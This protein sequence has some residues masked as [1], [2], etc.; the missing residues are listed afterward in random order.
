MSSSANK[1]LV[2]A[3]HDNQI[4]NDATLS[5]ISAA[6]AISAAVEV[7]VIGCNCLEVANQLSG[8][9]GVTKVILVEHS[10]LKDFL[11]EPVAEVITKLA[12]GYSPSG[13]SHIIAPSSSS[14]KEFMPRASAM[15]G[16]QMISEVIGIVDETTFIRPIYA[17]NAV[18]TVKSLQ[19]LHLLT[20]RKT[21]FAA[22]LKGSLRPEL[23]ERMAIELSSPL[24]EFM[25]LSNTPSERPELQ[26]AR[27]VVS[28]GRGVQNA[29]G[30]R[31]VEK[32]ADRLGAA[33]GASRALVDE[34][35]A[36][37]DW[38]VGQ[39]GKIVAPELYFA[40]GIS[41]AI[42]HIAGMRD[43]KVIVAINKDSGAPIFQVADYGLVGDFRN[44]LEELL[45]KL[46]T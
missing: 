4:V 33:I 9:A 26:N 44:I 5:A 41:G 7:A 23:I 12:S 3:A 46:G 35:V 31:L 19:N 11:A 27:V 13:Y 42:Q 22:A 32:L 29:D 36:P 15:L 17:G 37:N 18:T 2:I 10:A 25:G 20:I 28:A 21:S 6:I 43:S 30:L 16:V 39:T 14:S 38:Q 34:G 1:V 8:V 45:E 24:S 40:I